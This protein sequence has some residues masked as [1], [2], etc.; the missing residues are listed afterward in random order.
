MPERVEITY[1]VIDIDGDPRG[2]S[3]SDIPKDHPYASW[4]GKI[5]KQF[6]NMMH[7][8]R[9]DQLGDSGRLVISF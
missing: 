6:T 8:R 3:K 7:Q 4:I 2:V 9:R 1:R 5:Q